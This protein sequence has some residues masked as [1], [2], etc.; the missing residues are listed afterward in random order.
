MSDSVAPPPSPEFQQYAQQ[1]IVR[2]M[3]AY[4]GWTMNAQVDLI[5]L[6]KE[7]ITLPEDAR[8]LILDQLMALAERFAPPD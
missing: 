5:M 1:R 7:G 8:A 4:Q 6:A 2:M 3:Q